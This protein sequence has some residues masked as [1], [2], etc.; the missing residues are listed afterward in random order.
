MCPCQHPPN[1]SDSRMWGRVTPPFTA[2]QEATHTTILAPAARVAVTPPSLQQT[3]T[4]W[5]RTSTKGGGVTWSSHFSTDKKRGHTQSHQVTL[6]QSDVKEAAWHIYRQELDHECHSDSSIPHNNCT[7]LGSDP[8]PPTTATHPPHTLKKTTLALPD[9][10]QKC[11]EPQTEPASTACDLLTLA[12]S[13]CCCCCSAPVH[14]AVHRTPATA[15]HSSCPTSH[16]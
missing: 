15:N 6:G 2:T 3:N 1:W 11:S 14:T 7:T 12:C 13:C 10:Q 9:R 5:L 8:P 16:R 4:A